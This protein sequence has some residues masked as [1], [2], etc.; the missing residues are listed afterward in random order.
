[1]NEKYFG[2]F[3]NY[4]D[5]CSKT[6][7]KPHTES[8]QE[9]NSELRHKQSWYIL[10]GLKFVINQLLFALQNNFPVKQTIKSKKS[11]MCLVCKDYKQDVVRSTQFRIYLSIRF[12]CHCGFGEAWPRFYLVYSSCLIPASDSFLFVTCIVN[13]PFR[14]NRRSI[15]TQQQRYDLFGF[16]FHFYLLCSQ[17]MYTLYWLWS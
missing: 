13:S 1:M 7:T 4:C 15:A 14:C 3:I 9:T 11:F 5:F 6:E 16:F 17:C 10:Q 2:S 12:K 8:I